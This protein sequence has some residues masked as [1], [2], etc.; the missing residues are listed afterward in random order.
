MSSWRLRVTPVWAG[1]FLMGA[2]GAGCCTDVEQKLNR[3]VDGLRVAKG[4]ADKAEGESQGLKD[5]LADSQKETQRLR[6]LADQLGQR[7][8][9]LGQTVDSQAQLTAAERA[10]ALKDLE[11]TRRQLE[12]MKAAKA[13]AEERTGKL[14]ALLQR[15]QALI[16]SGK[17][18]VLVRDGRMVVVLASQV[19]FDAGRT[20][21]KPEGKKALAEVTAVLKAVSDRQ[22]QVAGHTDDTPL[23]MGP[24][25]SNW[26]LSTARAVEVVKLMQSQGMPPRQLSAAGYGEHSPVKPNTTAA[27]KAEN[28]RIEIVL[29]PRLDELPSLSDV[30]DKTE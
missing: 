25:R 6:V 22:F 26:E 5:A 8:Q 29:Q 20:L 30:L 21:V 28:R 12:E 19:L 24:Y 10:Q 14:R 27:G 3:C 23:R 18:R 4:K 7:L 13:R 9:A 15:F 17:I 2:L 1:L 11:E 16:Q